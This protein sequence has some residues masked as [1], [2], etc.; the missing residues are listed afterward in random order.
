MTHPYGPPGQDPWHAYPANPAY[1]QNPLTTVRP[2]SATAAAVLG[3][4]QA[5]LT[6][7]TTIVILFVLA[8][9]PA[10]VDTG[11]LTLAWIVTIAQ[12]AGAGMLIYG[13]VQLLGGVDRMI[14]LVA[15]GI[16]VAICLYYLVRILSA[17]V[18]DTLPSTVDGRPALAVFP[19]L[20][21]AMPVV[22]LG[23]AATAAVNT[24]TRSDEP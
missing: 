2:G 8:S 4:V 19:I 14:Y 3:F 13:S 7:C 18:S 15:A 22:G 12:A 11:E 9:V 20:F 6:L 21:A 17:D 5:G 1:R 16:E 24:W 10:T 23:L